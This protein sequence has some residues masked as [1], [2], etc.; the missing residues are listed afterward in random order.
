MHEDVIVGWVRQHPLMHENTTHQN[1]Q[2][3]LKVS[4]EIIPSTQK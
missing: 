3:K 4:R 2:R 1:Y